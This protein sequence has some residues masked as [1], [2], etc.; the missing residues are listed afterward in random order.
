MHLYN[1]NNRFLNLFGGEDRDNGQSLC[2]QIRCRSLL[3]DFPVLFI[4][5]VLATGIN[6][7]EANVLIFAERNSNPLK[8]QQVRGCIVGTTQSWE[9]WIY[10]QCTWYSHN[11]EICMQGTLK[12]IHQQ[13]QL[14]GLGLHQRL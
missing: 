3:P 6:L 13:K 11:G 1:L 7:T 5:N 9:T 2:D 12:K 14:L 8:D 10:M 4:Y